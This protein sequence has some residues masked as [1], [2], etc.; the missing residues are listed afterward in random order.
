MT[1]LSAIARRVAASHSLEVAIP[2]F[3]EPVSVVGGFVRDALLDLPHG[4]DIDLVV[5]G[6]AIAV[7]RRV[8]RA[9]GAMVLPYPQF[10]TATL[11]LPHGGEMDF[12]TARRETYTHPGALPDVEPGTLEDDLA[13]RDIAINAM[14]FRL[15]GPDA[16]AL[17]D[18][19]GGE[20]DIVSRTVRVLRDDAFLEDPSRVVR[21]ARYAARLGFDL[22]TR[23]RQLATE[24]ASTVAL[25]STRTAEE[26]ARALKEDAKTAAGTMA[27]LRQAGVAWCDMDHLG[28]F[29]SLDSA[30]SHPHAPPLPAWPLRLGW[31]V[32]VAD[33]RSAAL[34]GWARGLA[35]EAAAGPKLTAE[36]AAH[37]TAPSRIDALLSARKPAT[38]CAAF[39][40]GADVISMWWAD[41]QPLR[42]AIS[43]ADLVAAGVAPGPAIGRGLRAARAAALD[44]L[45]DTPDAQLAAAMDAAQ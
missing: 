7:A 20:G 31:A 17:V 23:T 18:P 11:E 5:E 14:A 33:I 45:A 1:D 44:G 22:D 28:A 39:A 16:F 38:V 26:F 37:N 43:G 42:L 41:W 35:E 2:L 29:P 34:P 40:L 12:V 30:L 36:L 32:P 24:A 15:S 19:H 21:A 3:T 4:A 6:D 25:T 8:G 13:R 10:G 9:L 27:L